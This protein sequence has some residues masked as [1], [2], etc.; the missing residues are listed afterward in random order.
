M[1]NKAIE[2]ESV[3]ESIAL[4]GGRGTVAGILT[5]EVRPDCDPLGSENKLIICPGLFGDTTAPCSGRIS[6]G[7]KSP[8]T[9]TIKEA[10][11]GGMAAKKLAALEIYAIVVESLPEASDSWYLLILDDSGATLLPGDKY[12][13]MNNYELVEN[14]KQD[15]HK[16]I[17]T[18]SIGVA[19]ERGY[20][21]STVQMTDPEGRPARAAA[22][23]GLGALMGS[24]RIKAVI[25]NT[26]QK[27]KASYQNRKKFLE[28][29]K[30]YS[31]AIL[32]NPISGNALPALGTPVLVNATNASGFLPTNNFSKG[33]FEHVENISG[34]NIAK[35]QS[36]RKGIMT[37][38][39]SPGCVIGC[40][41]VY[42][43]ENGRYLTSGFE[44]ETIGLMGSN[45]GID[46][47]DVIAKLDRMCDDFGID[48]METGTAI[49]VCMEAGKIE[50]GDAEGAVNLVREMMDGTPF[51]N[52]MGQGTA[53]T[54]QYL[55]VKRIPTVKGQSLAA[56][57]PRGLKGTG[58]TYA[59]SPMGADHTA[60][61]AF[62]DPSVDPVKKDGQVGLSTNLQVGMCL[63]DNLGMCIFSGFCL[64][65]P[66]NFQF[67]VE[68]AAGKFGGEWD[69]D[70]LMG[71][72][73]QTL[74]ME[75]KF[76]KDAGFTAKDN[77]LPDFFYKEKLESVD[78]VFD[79]TD[80]ELNAA[81]PF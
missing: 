77:R 20:L 46:T 21:N 16:D 66:E 64:A 36:P 44:Y 12:Q 65:Q 32:E 70:K 47:I 23:G 76:N 62:G 56:Y 49:G 5:A 61:N 31:K 63:F 43:D 17:A 29:S 69:L 45:C 54:G 18:I 34:E 26:N 7:G 48:T 2:F 8:L 42:N 30:G 38:R 28:S 75:K 50:F 39:C 3:P 71:I 51:G 80:D 53:R 68:M 9:G 73:V 72:A 33:R 67:L 59:T 27:L 57:D 4:F 6:I 1:H 60:G 78:T 14:L 40:S 52:I 13:G 74:S 81:I 41:S 37:H 22:R 55:G 19:G 15:F 25:I 11:A 79:F 24:K 35:I 58:V 10:N